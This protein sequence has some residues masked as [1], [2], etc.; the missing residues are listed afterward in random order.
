MNEPDPMDETGIDQRD[1]RR[2]TAH[3]RAGAPC[4]KFAMRGQNVCR[5]HG[6]ASP[7]ALAKAQ[8]AI[9]RADMKIRG[10]A[11]PAVDAIS[12]SCRQRARRS[13]WL[14]PKIFSTAVD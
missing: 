9:E 14:L 3:N 5:N 11:I 7:Q 4:G 6:G 13:S 2:C 10:L 12:G 1:P 8:A